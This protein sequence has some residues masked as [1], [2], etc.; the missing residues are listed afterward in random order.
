M[1][2]LDTNVL[3]ELRKRG[4]CNQAVARW[5]AGIRSQEIYISVL[6]LGELRRGIESIRRRDSA[7][8]EALDKW[9]EQLQ[10][11]HAERMLP[12]DARVAGIWGRINVPDPMP[13]VDGLLAATALR[14][15][16]VLTTRNTSD[17]VRSGARLLNPWTEE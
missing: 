5:F 16:L 10:D 15:D 8:A 17:V 13:A 6:V 9:V 4:R 12:V 2:L 1:Y 7:G 3:S 11:T 14:H